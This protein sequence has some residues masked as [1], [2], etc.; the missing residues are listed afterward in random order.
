MVYITGDMHGDEDRLYDKNMR[1]LKEGDILIICGDFGFIWSGDEKE[2]KLLDYLG[3][4]KYTVCFLDGTHENY[5][6][7]SK[8]RETVWKGGRVHRIC[9]NLFMRFADPGSF[10]SFADTHV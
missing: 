1:K 4:R 6:L 10:K 8:Y 7:L 5:N 2:K 3:S 9:G